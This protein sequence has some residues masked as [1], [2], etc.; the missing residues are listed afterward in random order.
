MQTLYS[1]RLI[2]VSAFFFRDFQTQCYVFPS[3]LNQTDMLHEYSLSQY[4]PWA[5]S[6][7]G[8]KASSSLFLSR[9]VHGRTPCQIR[10]VLFTFSFMCQPFPSYI[11]R[12]FVY[13]SHAF[14]LSLDLRWGIISLFLSCDPTPELLCS[15]LNLSDL[16][17]LYGYN[18]S[19]TK[20]HFN[21]HP[22]A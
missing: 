13:S 8:D 3:Y 5:H 9:L 18:Y 10:V 22:L 14:C 1:V 11:I 19:L 4:K 7:K 15:C 6:L 2:S 16:G 21:S 20:E 17:Q 12:R